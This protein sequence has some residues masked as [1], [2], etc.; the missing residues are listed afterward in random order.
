MNVQKCDIYL[1]LASPLG[2]SSQAENAKRILQRNLFVRESDIN[3]YV[4]AVICLVGD[5]KVSYYHTPNLETVY[6]C[7]GLDGQ[8]FL[9]LSFSVFDTPEEAHATINKGFPENTTHYV[10][11]K[12][13]LVNGDICLKRI[14]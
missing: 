9:H 8:E 1:E 13:T 5:N 11:E 14:D 7:N 2:F 12:I 6:W 10:L 3:K 4:A